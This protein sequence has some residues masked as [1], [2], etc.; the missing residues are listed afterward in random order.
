MK[1]KGYK[2]KGDTWDKLI[3][4]ILDAAAYIKKHEEQ[5][6]QTTCDLHIRV[7]KCTEADSGIFEHLLWSAINVISVWQI[8]CLTLN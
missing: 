3:A 8:C 5:L 1:S 7:T 6:Q 2:R 4:H